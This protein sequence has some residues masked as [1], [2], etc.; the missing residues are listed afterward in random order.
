MINYTPFVDVATV[1]G[2]LYNVVNEQDDIT[3]NDAWEGST[4]GVGALVVTVISAVVGAIWKKVARIHQRQFN[5]M[6]MPQ[7]PQQQN[8]AGDN[9]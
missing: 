8:I 1:I 4:V 6:P 9:V 7:L 2:D 5:Q 3:D